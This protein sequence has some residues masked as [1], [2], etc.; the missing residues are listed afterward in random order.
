MYTHFIN[1][2]IYELTSG[3]IFFDSIIDER[4]TPTCYPCKSPNIL[5]RAKFH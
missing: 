5:M 3:V 1:K 2:D 4:G